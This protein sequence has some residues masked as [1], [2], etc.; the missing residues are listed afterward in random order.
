MPKRPSGRLPG[1]Y[2][3]GTDQTKQLKRKYNGLLFERV[4]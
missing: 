2:N 1:G 4:C 3:P